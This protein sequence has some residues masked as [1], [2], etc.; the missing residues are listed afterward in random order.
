[1]E[2]I[3]PVRPQTYRL[4]LTSC[5]CH[6][7][8]T[9]KM[10]LARLPCVSL[11]HR[12]SVTPLDRPYLEPVG[13]GTNVIL[14]LHD[15]SARRTLEVLVP[16]TERLPLCRRMSLA[17]SPVVRV[18][19]ADITDGPQYRFLSVP[20]STGRILSFAMVDSFVEATGSLKRFSYSQCQIAWLAVGSAALLV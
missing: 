7:A 10:R 16:F 8:V 14:M 3:S 4:P 2:T 15:L 1:M 5:Q 19:T 17:A 13:A 6:P 18:V 12:A 20:C 11:S 9:R